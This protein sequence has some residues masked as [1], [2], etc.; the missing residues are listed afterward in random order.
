MLLFSLNIVSLIS[1]YLKPEV[2]ELAL[3]LR[4]ALCS[5]YSDITDEALSSDYTAFSCWICS[6]EEARKE[7]KISRRFVVDVFLVCQDIFSTLFF[8]FRTN[9]DTVLQTT[10]SSLSMTQVLAG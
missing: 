3:S 5:P 9:V 10:Q 6:A 7:S 1:R 2:S 8:I 4:G